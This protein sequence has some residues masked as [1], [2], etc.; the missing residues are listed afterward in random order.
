MIGVITISETQ[1]TVYA[2]KNDDNKDELSKYD[3]D[4]L[5]DASED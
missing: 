5:C 4:F 3:I 2:D 1:Q